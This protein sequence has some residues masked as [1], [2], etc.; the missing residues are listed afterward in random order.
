MVVLTEVEGFDDILVV[1]FGSRREAAWIVGCWVGDLRAM[2]EYC[3]VSYS[4]LDCRR[5]VGRHGI[6]RSLMRMA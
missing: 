1:C 5:D 3:R 4:V 2:S 6:F